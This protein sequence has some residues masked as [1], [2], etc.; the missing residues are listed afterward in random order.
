[1]VAP[2]IHCTKYERGCGLLR[3]Q[4]PDY[5]AYREEL[6]RIHEIKRKEGPLN[7]ISKIRKERYDKANRKHR[8][9][10]S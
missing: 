5:I 1:M 4:C 9:D 3:S 8:R 10:I 7:E 6:D 2:C